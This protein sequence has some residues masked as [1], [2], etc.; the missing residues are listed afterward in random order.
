MASKV[1]IQPV[2][3]LEFPEQK[4]AYSVLFDKAEVKLKDEGAVV[5]YHLLDKN[6]SLVF[7]N[8]L[9]ELTNEEIAEWTT[10]DEQLFDIVLQKLNLTKVNE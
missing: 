1:N 4:F 8:G 6:N 3:V 5:L 9:M 2:K 7:Q 10:T